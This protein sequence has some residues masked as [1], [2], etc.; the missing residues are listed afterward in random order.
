VA[1][2]MRTHVPQKQRALEWAKSWLPSDA[3]PIVHELIEVR[4]NNC[5][6]RVES[7]KHLT[8]GA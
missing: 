4:K 1:A 2:V 8:S 3:L 5:A 6:D 7:V